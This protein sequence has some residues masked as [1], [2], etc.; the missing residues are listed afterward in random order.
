[1]DTINHKKEKELTSGAEPAKA[2][3][4]AL[5]GFFTSAGYRFFVGEKAFFYPF[6]RK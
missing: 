3:H 5:F 2:L 6:S 4:T 1:M